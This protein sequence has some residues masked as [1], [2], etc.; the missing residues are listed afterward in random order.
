MLKIC[1][2][3]HYN[4]LKIIEWLEE[5][6]AYG[7][8]LENWGVF[9]VKFKESTGGEH[10]RYQIDMDDTADEP[11]GFRRDELAKNGWE[12][13][14]TIGNSR[15]H[16]YRCR[17]R[18]ASLPCNEA[19]IEYNRKKLNKDLFWSCISI[20]L[21]V[22]FLLFIYGFRNE[23]VLLE[24]MQQD[25]IKLLFYT[26]WIAL[27][28]FQIFGEI[29]QNVKLYRYLDKV[30]KHSALEV[31][32]EKVEKGYGFHFPVRLLAW[33]LLV[34]SL[35][36][37]LWI[38]DMEDVANLSEA[39]ASVKYVDLASFQ[40]EG[41]EISEITWEDHPDVNFGNRIEYIWAPLSKTYYEIN[42]YGR[43]AGEDSDEQM[44][45]MYWDVTN[46]KIADRLF[47]QVIERY[48]KYSRYYRGGFNTEKYYIEENWTVTEQNDERFTQ[49]VIAEGG[50]QRYEGNVQI[51]VRIGNQIICLRYWGDT[52]AEVLV[53]A[54]AREFTNYPEK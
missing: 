25:S 36:S 31:E 52:S 18:K 29:Y 14:T 16:I 39:D 21:L 41:F 34:C 12:Y 33:I 40:T 6:S 42:Q 20:L 8:E 11:N 28:L 3:H 43:I 13:V 4:L 47:S 17:D 1:P 45:G 49:L 38:D 19:Y 7:W 37:L 54:V 48:T 35:V 53:E 46:E 51:F 44:E 9:F 2:F 50:G 32:D 24:F 15:E 30:G 22:L 26:V 10:F 27:T 5:Q 23:F